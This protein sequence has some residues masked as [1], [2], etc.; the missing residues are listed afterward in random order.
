MGF[1]ERHER[2]RAAEIHAQVPATLLENRAWHYYG[3]ALE[4]RKPT[5]ANLSRALT[6]PY[7]RLKGIRHRASEL[8]PAALR[9]VNL[10]MAAEGLSVERGYARPKVDAPAATKQARQLLR[11][12]AA[13]QTSGTIRRV[14]AGAHLIRCAPPAQHCC[15]LFSPVSPVSLSKIMSLT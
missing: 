2:E 7:P 4:Q 13:D 12:I 8:I 14:M 9:H 10:S 11:G 3:A 1:K 5:L 15:C 6:T